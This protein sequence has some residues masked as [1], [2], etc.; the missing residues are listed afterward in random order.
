MT[1]FQMSAVIGSACHSQIRNIMESGIHAN[2]SPSNRRTGPAERRVLGLGLVT[3][4]LYVLTWQ[5]EGALF[6]DSNVLQWGGPTHAANGAPV[7]DL[8][9][10]RQERVSAACR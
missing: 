10:Q 5:F 6:R 9:C 8:V 7:V 1:R 2:V 4:A 3:I